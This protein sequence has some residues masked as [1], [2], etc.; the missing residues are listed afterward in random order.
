MDPSVL[1]KQGWKP[2]FLDP[3]EMYVRGMNMRALVDARK[4]QQIQRQ[5]AIEDQERKRSL[6]DLLRTNPNA[7][8]EDILRTDPIAGMALI[9]EQ[10]A[11][12]KEQRLAEEAQRRE[13]ET[14]QRILGA[15][16]TWQGNLA[17]SLLKVAD[18]EKR[19]QLFN[20]YTPGMRAV[21]MLTEEEAAEPLGDD[22]LLWRLVE[23]GLGPSGAQD[24]R[25]KIAKAAREAELHTEA[26][27]EKPYERRKKAAEAQTAEGVATGTQPISPAEERRL[28]VSERLDDPDKIALALADPTLPPY[29]RKQLEAARDAMIQQRVL[30]AP[31]NMPLSPPVLEQRIKLAEATAG[32]KPMSAEASKVS[33]IA[34]TLVPEARQLQEAI[35]TGGREAIL[36]ILTGTDTNLARL[37]D[38]VADKVGRLRS[39]GAVNPSEEERFKG[40]LA[41]WGDIRTGDTK[42]AIDAIDRLIGEAETVRGGMQRGQQGTAAPPAKPPEATTRPATNEPDTGIL[43]KAPNGKTY[44]FRTKAEADAFKREAG[45]K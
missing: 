15:K 14:A 39:G 13:Q 32:A 29:K 35:R 6:L 23:R 40:Q 16:R 17:G 5:F 44:Y 24:L 10:D 27:I 41:R 26:M 37:A 18:P 38:N 31:Q 25:D 12:L 20:Q 28:R 30:T 33:S 8:R 9:K 42:A 1:L 2:E 34:E 21:D 43:V 19:Q 45:I 3:Q 22:S 36:G 4:A 7:T 11:Q